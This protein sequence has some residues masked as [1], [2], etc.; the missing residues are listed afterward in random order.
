MF[1]LARNCTY[2]E[3]QISKCW[4]ITVHL[5]IWEI[6]LWSS[7][8]INPVGDSDGVRFEK[9]QDIRNSLHFLMYSYLLEY[10]QPLLL[11]WITRVHP[12]K[13]GPKLTFCICWLSFHCCQ[14]GVYTVSCVTDLCCLPAGVSNSH[15]TKYYAVGL[16]VAFRL[17]LISILGE[18]TL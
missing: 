11:M 17:H 3:W 10:K 12:Q 7:T 18:C 6:I 14:Y 1:L 15:T 13:L 2:L 9:M 16:G 4:Y 8:T 5:F